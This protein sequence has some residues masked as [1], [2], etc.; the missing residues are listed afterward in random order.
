MALHVGLHRSV[1]GAAP[2]ASKSDPSSSASSKLT[3]FRAVFCISS[4]LTSQSRLLQVLKKTGTRDAN[5]TTKIAFPELY[6][7]HGVKDGLVPCAWGKRTFETLQA[8]QSLNV[9]DNLKGS[10]A[11]N[12]E[13]KKAESSSSSGSGSIEFHSE[14]FLD[15]TLGNLQLTKLASWISSMFFLEAPDRDESNL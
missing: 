10:A 15:H 6:M 12:G 1:A 9:T 8:A 14:P 2:T 5:N 13:K 3:S 11:S 4:F 7:S